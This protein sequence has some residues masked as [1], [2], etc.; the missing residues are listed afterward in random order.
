MISDLS[1]YTD[2]GRQ[3]LALLEQ[4]IAVLDG[5]MGT[6]IQ[7]F[8]LEE[9]DYRKGK[10]ED[11][12]IDLKGNNDLLVF[13]RPEIVEE[14]HLKFLEAGSDII[15]TNTFS[16]TTIAQADYGLESIVTELN[17][18]AARLAKNVVNKFMS[19]NP[20]RDCYVAGAIGPTNKTA[21][22]SPD[23]NRPEYRATSFDELKDAYFQQ[24]KALVEGGVD[25]LLP[26]T[27]FDTLN[28]KAAL[29]AIEDYFEEA[30]VRLPVIV[31][32]TITDQSGRT[33]SGQ[34]VT[35]F[36]NS[37][38]H[39]QPTCVGL[40]CALGAE[41]MRPYVE[42][43]S[44]VADCYVHCYPNAGLPNPL[45]E[46]GYDETPEH[47]G[48]AVGSFAQDGLVNLVG[49]CCGTTPEHIAQI[50]LEVKKY[51]PRKLPQLNPALKL[52]GL[53]PS[54]FND[55]APFIMVGE[56]C[57]VTGS[58]KFRK[59]IKNG[60]FEEAVSV[61]RQQVEKGAHILDVCFDEGMLDG[62]ECMTH[63]LNLIAAEPDICKIPVMV[64]SS[65]WEVLE[66]GLKCVQGKGIVNSISLKEGEEKFIKIA[67]TI[68]RYGAA[69]VVMAFDEKGQ[70]ASKDD[71][72]SI[73]KRSFKILTEVVGMNPNDIIFDLNILT[74]A[75]GMEEHNNYAVDFIEA[76]REVKQSCKGCRTS[77][78]VSNISFA[79]RGNNVVREAMHGAFLYHAQKAGLDMGIV[80]A[81]LLEEYDKIQPKLLEMVENVLLNKSPEATE[82]LI[83]YADELKAQKGKPTLAG[84]VEE[85]LSNALIQGMTKLRDMF[86]EAL[87][88]RDPAL[89]EQ[90]IDFAEK[91]APSKEEDKKKS[92]ASPEKH[93]R[94]T[95]QKRPTPPRF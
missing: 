82:K 79:F 44:R 76:V 84:P 71:K 20:D 19:Q 90:F 57:N 52:S 1:L 78:G 63:F 70:A 11:S 49:G 40:N 66:A 54:E 26:E 17:L 89:I 69:V 35:A 72:V 92:Q 30:G 23:V 9:I 59:L 58:P 33:L 62:V 95:P 10:F 73:A 85:R 51:K 14:V 34:T 94:K 8:K 4:R 61:A 38:S 80:N 15:E 36:W 6:M 32:A 42:E 24:V 91:L 46:T 50:A 67:K 5:A 7:R 37:I 21:S 68:N 81:G 64:D 60:D 43:L 28:L 47:T 75:T 88:K 31:S 27:T 22:M 56:R 74:V 2:R 41:L 87:N 55:S 86:E 18:E 45:A 16:G 77:G 25:L 48:N 29:Y 93:T 83:D 12:E 65:K 13:T 39:A 53:E 3:F